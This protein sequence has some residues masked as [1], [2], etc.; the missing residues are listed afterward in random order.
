M[1]KIPLIARRSVLTALL[2][3][4]LSLGTGWAQTAVTYTANSGCTPRLRL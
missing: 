4:T 1:K 2:G 3:C